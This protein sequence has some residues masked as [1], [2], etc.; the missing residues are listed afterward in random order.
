MK[1]LPP[2]AATI[3][4]CLCL[5]GTKPGRRE[6]PT[7]VT[8]SITRQICKAPWHF[9]HTAAMT[10]AECTIRCGS[11]SCTSCI[12]SLRAVGAYKPFARRFSVLPTSQSSLQKRVR[13]LS[14]WLTL[15]RRSRCILARSLGAAGA[16]AVRRTW[17]R[18]P[19]QKIPLSCP[20]SPAATTTKAEA[21]ESS[22]RRP[23][24]RNPRPTVCVGG[25]VCGCGRSRLTSLLHV[26]LAVWL[27]VICALSASAAPSLPLHKVEEDSKPPAKPDSATHME[28]ASSSAAGMPA[29][30]AVLVPE[31]AHF[32]FHKWFRCD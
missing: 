28:S 25:C 17:T 3:Q 18:Y 7:V 24:P 8:T 23:S 22:S 20:T 27:C 12:S 30:C 11:D 14:V 31:L 19:T 13:I 15:R 29:V 21:K 2:A 6:T 26:C 5:R 16:A 4:R 10:A 9:E 32:G 1:L